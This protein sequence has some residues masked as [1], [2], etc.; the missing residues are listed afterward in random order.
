MANKMVDR[1]KKRCREFPK[2]NWLSKEQIQS[3]FSWLF[4]ATK[5]TVDLNKTGD[6]QIEKMVNEVTAAQVYN[7][8]ENKC[9]DDQIVVTGEIES[10]VEEGVSGD[11]PIIYIT[12]KDGNGGF[13]GFPGT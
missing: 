4:T 9:Y 5:K 6:G 12:L 7:A 13:S 1:T 10:S 3:F 11:H 8:Q 2:E